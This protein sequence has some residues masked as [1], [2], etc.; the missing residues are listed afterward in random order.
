[1]P[2]HDLM[3]NAGG[4]MGADKRDKDLFI[5]KFL[6]KRLSACLRWRDLYK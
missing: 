2:V 4:K 6:R 1:M 3:H 5:G